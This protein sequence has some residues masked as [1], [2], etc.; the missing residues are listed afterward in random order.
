MMNYYC[1][2][3]KSLKFSNLPFPARDD[4]EAIRSVRNMLLSADDNILARVVPVC[5]LRYCGAF[6]EQA[7][8]FSEGVQT[9]LVCSLSS[10]PVSQSE[11]G[12]T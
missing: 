11:G 6:D 3:D 10:I 12:D 8:C 4:N 1:I 5:E 2:Y 9:R 7:A